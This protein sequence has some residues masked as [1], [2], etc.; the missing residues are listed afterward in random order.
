MKIAFFGSSLVSAYW[1]GTATY[2]RGILRALHDRGHT[3]IFYEPDR[4]DRQQHRDLPNPEYASSVVYSA[5]QPSDVLK[6]LETA[7]RN[8][9]LVVKASGIGVFDALMEEAV[10]DLRSRQTAVAFWDVDAAATLERMRD[11]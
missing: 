4:S 6:T 11:N 2:Y 5:T 10:L 8:A 1:N 3:I 9:D 7:A